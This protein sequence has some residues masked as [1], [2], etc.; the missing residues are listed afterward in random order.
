MKGILDSESYEEVEET[1]DVD[2]ACEVDRGLNE[3]ALG[4]ERTSGGGLLSIE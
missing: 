3:A 4:E 2:R 1:Y